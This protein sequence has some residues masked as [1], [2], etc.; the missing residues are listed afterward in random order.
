V[1]YVLVELDPEPFRVQVAI[2]QAAANL[3]AAGR[4]CAVRSDRHGAYALN[5]STRLRML[6]TKTLDNLRGRQSSALGY[7]D[8]FF[9][10]AAIAGAL[11]FL[12]FLMKR[13]VAGKG[14]HVAAE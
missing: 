11:V 9:L 10:F 7:F 5:S 2:K 8:T 3:V 4:R 12:V 1:P 14:A 6:T 13:S